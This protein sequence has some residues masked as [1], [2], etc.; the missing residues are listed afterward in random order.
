PWQGQR[1]RPELGAL[2]G[3]VDPLDRRRVLG[4]ADQRVVGAA[5]HDDRAP[6]RQG[7]GRRRQGARLGFVD[8]GHC[9]PSSFV[10]VVVAV[11]VGV[12]VTAG[13]VVSVAGDVAGGT[14][15]REPA[16][17]TTP[18]AAVVAAS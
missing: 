15:A 6:F 5:G 8:N 1:E 2:L 18:V 17:N 3:L 10:V 12:A 4:I 14:A 7:G 16:R 11:V 9:R 13:A